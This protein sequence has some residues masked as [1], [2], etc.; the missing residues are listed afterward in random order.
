MVIASKIAKSI[1]SH[2]TSKS[3]TS[4]TGPPR[5]DQSK[6]SRFLTAQRLLASSVTIRILEFKSQIMDAGLNPPQFGPLNQRLDT[7][8]SFTSMP[9][10]DKIRKKGEQAV[11]KKGTNWESEVGGLVHCLINSSD[12]SS[13]VVLQSSICHAHV[14]LPRAPV[15]FSIS[16]L[17]SSWSRV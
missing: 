7:L 15:P 3:R 12:R 9:S 16:V 17:A 11:R 6:C 1:H 14:L 8:E 10:A 2:E 4:R 13:R 5:F